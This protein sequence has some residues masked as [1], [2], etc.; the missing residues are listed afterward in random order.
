M[1]DD[2]KHRGMVIE[3][4]FRHGVQLRQESPK[5]SYLVGKWWLGRRVVIQEELHRGCVL[6]DRPP[7]GGNL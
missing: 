1:N 3:V 2:D 4:P 5:F 7:R 6:N